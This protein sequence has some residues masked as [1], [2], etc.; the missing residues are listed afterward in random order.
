SPS[1]SAP[2]PAASLD[3]YPPNISTPRDCPASANQSATSPHT[4]PSP[5]P[6]SSP[7]AAPPRHAAVATRDTAA[8]LSPVH[9]PRAST[10]A[11][12]ERSR[13]APQMPEYI[14]RSSRQGTIRKQKSLASLN[15]GAYSKPANMRTENPASLV[16]QTH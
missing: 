16:V 14:P 1:A 11:N 13:S 8:A 6:K 10:T 12:S 5:K 9:Q 2:S 3:A 15:A 7:P 4:A